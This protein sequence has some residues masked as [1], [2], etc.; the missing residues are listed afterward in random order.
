[1]LD[2][3]E[4]K[5]W[6]RALKPEGVEVVRYILEWISPVNNRREDGPDA[7]QSIAKP[8]AFPCELIVK[9]GT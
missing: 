5:G 3:C 6:D 2:V 1:M 4:V 8:S 7:A 9:T